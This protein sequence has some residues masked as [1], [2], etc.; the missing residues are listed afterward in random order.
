M[1]EASGPAPGDPSKP[2]TIRDYERCLRRYGFREAL[3]HVRV[4]E[5]RTTDAQRWVDDMVRSSHMRPA[6]IDTAVTPLKA[7][8]R[9][10]IIRGDATLNP[11]VGIMKPAVRCEV[12]NVVS[13]VLA[14]AVLEVLPVEDRRLLPGCHRRAAGRAGVDR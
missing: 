7:F 10:A 11:F 4:R 3:G 8:Y 1:P 13:P 6:T 9:R 2:G 5:L 12:R 14:A